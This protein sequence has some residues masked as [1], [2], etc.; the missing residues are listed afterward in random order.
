MEVHDGRAGRLRAGGA[1]ELGEGDEAWGSSAPTSSE[2][3]AIVM[4]GWTSWVGTIKA[5]S[6][7]ELG[8]GWIVE[9]D[10]AGGGS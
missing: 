8:G 6:I 7:G 1:E 9:S 3:S 4:C 10:D 5:R 2:F